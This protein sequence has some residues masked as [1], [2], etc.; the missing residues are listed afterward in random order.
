MF[1]TKVRDNEWATKFR[2]WSYHFCS[3][4]LVWSGE[5]H[6]RSTANFC[7]MFLSKD[8]ER[9][10]ASNNVTHPDVKEVCYYTQI[11]ALFRATP[12]LLKS[13][14]AVLAAKCDYCI[15]DA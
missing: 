12:S 2:E 11:Q 3:R 7:N 1:V 5:F 14:L 9:K 10:P 4:V 15:T 6:V 13:F 8:S